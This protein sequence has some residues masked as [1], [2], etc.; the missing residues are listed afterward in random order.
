M[1]WKV[2]AFGLGS[3]PRGINIADNI[4]NTDIVALGYDAVA[5][6]PSGFVWKQVDRV[7]RGFAG[8]GW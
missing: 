3:G 1:S 8:Y 5:V 7:L 6:Y 4:N 2:G